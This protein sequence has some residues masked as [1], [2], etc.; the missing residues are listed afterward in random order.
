MNPNGASYGEDEMLYPETGPSTFTPPTLGGE[1]GVEAT[2]LAERVTQQ[3]MVI[4][5]Q[6]AAIKV[7]EEQLARVTDQLQRLA[8]SAP[9]GGSVPTSPTERR[10]RGPKG[11]IPLPEKFDGTPEKLRPFLTG[12][13]IY[14]R[15]HEIFRVTDK[16]LT[17]GANFK[18]APARWFQ[19]LADDYLANPN[20]LR[21][22]TQEAFRD[23]NEFRTVVTKMFGQ[24]DEEA[25]AVQQ[26]ERI[27]QHKSV[28]EYTTR[29]KQL[30][31]RLDWGDSPLRRAFY[32]GLKDTVKDGLMYAQPTK[33]LQELVDLATQV[34]SRIYE[35]HQQKKFA[36]PT[37]EPNEKVKRHRAKDKDG[38]TVMTGQVKNKNKKNFKRDGLSKEER[39]RRYDSR[40]CLGCGKP[41]HFRDSCP[42]NQPT[43]TVKEGAIKLAMIR[44]PTPYPPEVEP[45]D[46]DVSDLDLYEEARQEN[47]DELRESGIK[48]RK[49][50]KSQDDWTRITKESTGIASAIALGRLKYY[51]PGV[52]G[53]ELPERLHLE[54]REPRIEQ[55]L[56]T[57]EGLRRICRAGCNPKEG[58]EETQQCMHLP[59]HGSLEAGKCALRNCPFHEDWRSKEHQARHWSDCE[60]NCR[61]HDGTRKTTGWRVHDPWHKTVAATECQVEN[62]LIH[63]EGAKEVE[64]P[65]TVLEI[66][67][68]IIR[69]LDEHARLNFR[70]CYNNDCQVHYDAKYGSGFFPQRLRKNLNKGKKSKN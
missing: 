17:T 49:P 43:K 41:G 7:L 38:D 30:Q 20:N 33:T 57:N 54:Q 55:W 6:Q 28:G 60:L 63:H 31:A 67:D 3:N 21:E 32:N 62:C 11:K 69:K 37:S 70:F 8:D 1:S 48:I 44:S 18:D 45:S 9:M 61:Y 22:D 2:P 47:P 5:Q 14:F 10:E 19:P 29:F 24:Q 58:H 15:H 34:D 59:G 39:Q 36:R 16:I 42:D 4:D 68:Q 12:M 66:R 27:K 52:T 23:W 51:A 50:R 53:D 13:E 25:Q 65:S 26:M 46:E 40:A 35:R 64:Q 56:E